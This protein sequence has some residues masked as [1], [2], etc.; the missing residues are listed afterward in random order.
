MGDEVRAGD[1]NVRIESLTGVGSTYSGTGTMVWNFPIQSVLNDGRDPIAVN[2][3]FNGISINTD[4][5]LFEGS[6]EITGMGISL[7]P[8]ELSAFLD[9]FGDAELVSSEFSGGGVP[10]IP[11][12]F[13]I[14]GTDRIYASPTSGVIVITGEDGEEVVIEWDGDDTE[15]VDA[16]GN[17][18]VVDEEGNVSDAGTLAEG[19]IPTPENTEGVNAAGELES[20][21]RLGIV[22]SESSTAVY[23]FDTVPASADPSVKRL[24]RPY[25]I[26]ESEEIYHTVYKAVL[27]NAEDVIE[28]R[29]LD[30]SI[31]PED[32]VFKSMSGRRIPADYD[33]SRY[34]LT[35]TGWFDNAEEKIIAIL[36]GDEIPDEV[37]GVFHLT[38]LSGNRD[39]NILLVPLTADASIPDMN[40]LSQ[41]VM[42]GIGV[43]LNFTIVDAILPPD[44][45]LGSDG[46]LECVGTG[47]LDTYSSEQQA[48]I[49]YVKRELGDQYRNDAYYILY[50]VQPSRNLGGFMPLKRQFGFVFGDESEEEGKSSTAL[51]TLHEIGHGIYGLEHPWSR[52]DVAG[53][54]LTDWLMDYGGGE[55]LGHLYWKQIYDP[56][57]R[58]Y[59][60]QREDEGQFSPYE[61]LVGR[62]VIP[63]S[64]KEA[65]KLE[66]SISFISRPGKVITLPDEVTDVSFFN[67]GVLHAFT[68]SDERYVA[69]KWT[70]DGKFS[71]YVKEFGDAKNLKERA[72]ID[73]LSLERSNQQG[74][75]VFLGLIDR[76]GQCGIQAYEGVLLNHDIKDEYYGGEGLT[77]ASSETINDQLIGLQG[78]SSNPYYG[79]NIKKLGLP[80]I[81]SPEA[82]S[83]CDYGVAFYNEYVHTL[84]NEIEADQLFETAKTICEF[85]N[86]N[87]AQA[88]DCSN[89]KQFADEINTWFI[90]RSDVEEKDAI[91]NQFWSQESAWEL[92]NQSLNRYIEK[93]TKYQSLIES[94]EID[95]SILKALIN[96]SHP[97]FV[98]LYSLEERIR[99]IKSL[100]LETDPSLSSVDLIR[101]FFVSNSEENAIL[102]VI[103]TVVNEAEASYVLE[104][105]SKDGFIQILNHHID[106]FG[107][108]GNNYTELSQAFQRLTLLKNNFDPKN[109]SPEAIGHIPEEHHLIYNDDRT[110]AWGM[111]AEEGGVKFTKVEYDES[112]ELTIEFQVCEKTDIRTTTNYINGDPVTVETEYCSEISTPVTLGLHYFDP[113]A[114]K[115]IDLRY[116]PEDRNAEAGV[117]FVTYAGFVDYLLE[118]RGTAQVKEIA[119]YTIST[120]AL[121]LG[122]GEVA[123]LIRGGAHMGR[124]ALA[125]FDFGTE[126][127]DAVLNSDVFARHVCEGELDCEKLKEYQLYTT[128]AQLGAIAG[129]GFDILSNWDLLKRSDVLDDAL[130]LARGK[131]ND[132][133]VNSDRVSEIF[134]LA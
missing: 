16:D 15:I 124:V 115:I 13:S 103:N 85:G 90:W 126:L 37:I 89:E 104:E 120:A 36:P 56:A 11:I 3:A 91:R 4:Y 12:D 25:P 67:D 45:L 112:G 75:S 127:A 107:F 129:S 31:S 106:D 87:I 6:M 123:L 76:N 130:A 18:F 69:S 68:Y 55:D 102:N 80:K 133:G 84:S 27:K 119:N 62:N 53:P 51:T 26:R 28:A 82:C 118:K 125:T 74:Y 23:T 52:Y 73:Q 43:Q 72:Y 100:L 24:Y 71:G 10:L 128:L 93:F 5:E 44:E 41:S 32:V 105:F 61:Y 122:A 101:E 59:V 95:N 97:E 34:T 7:I 88:F 30:P 70:K 65:T 81:E 9:A 20:L 14:S 113:I 66:G 49:D 94:G 40:N 29:I 64:F 60:F 79:N 8:P 108:G 114:I 54:N 38:H 109:I 42:S 19:G 63:G 57:L 77:L 2:I 35:V 117:A 78:A 47:L 83:L 121:A 1:F 134:V 96:G 21:T 132:L 92:Y 98:K 46:L 111:P 17:V 110:F 39:A 58:L 22:F 33:G 99:M 48:L 86:E 116:L 131:L 50:G